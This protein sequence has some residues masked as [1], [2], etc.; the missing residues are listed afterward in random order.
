MNLSRR[1]M[2]LGAALISASSPVRSQRRQI[3][4]V[5]RDLNSVDGEKDLAKY[6]KAVKIMMD[7][8]EQDPKSWM[9]QWYIHSIPSDRKKADELKRLYPVASENAALAA[10]SWSTCQAHMRGGMADDFLPWHRMYLLCFETTIRSL[11]NDPSFALPYWNYT[12]KD[13]RALPEQFR[14]KADPVF[15]VLY[16]SGRIPAV[17]AGTPIDAGLLGQSPINVLS[18]T[19]TNYGPTGLRTGFCRDIDSNLH[20]SIHVRVGNTM[21]MGA[22]PWAANDPIFWLHHA[23]IDRLWASWNQNGGLNPQGAWLERS[24]VFP[25]G[26]GGRKV[27]KNREVLSLVA[28]GYSYDEL[29][30]GPTILSA[31]ASPLTT[32]QSLLATLDKPLVV[33]EVEARIKLRPVARPKGIVATASAR[34]YLVISM[35]S[36]PA[37]P[38]VLYR[39]DMEVG[40]NK[41]V[42]IGHINF[43]DSV[44]DPGA[45]NHQ[46][47][48]EGRSFSFDVTDQL[49]SVSTMP[50]V[51]VVPADKPES[52]LSVTIGKIELIQS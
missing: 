40:R 41:W 11:L 49:A 13:Q 46:H 48:P 33:T 5:R 20:G 21:G 25:D 50:T 35:L 24:Y 9:F 15:N 6:A 42:T 3:S 14:R 19:Q 17:N 12:R 7:L 31:T 26:T 37:A 10:E 45:P 44:E 16:R 36:A 27:L 51:R 30:P 47:S 52:G 43:F 23:N 28:A 38:G 29:E 32:R 18:L 34:T 39:V 1:E 2:V 4:S 8:P 22:V